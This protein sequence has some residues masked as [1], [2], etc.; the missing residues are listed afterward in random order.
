MCFRSGDSHVKENPC[1]GRPCM[2]VAL[3]NE[4]NLHQVVCMNWPMV[5]TMLKNSVL[6]L[7]VCFMK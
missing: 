3:Q 6:W 5:V 2:A 7:R 4:E 1:S